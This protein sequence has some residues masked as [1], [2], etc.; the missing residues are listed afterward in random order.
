[1]TTC[2]IGFYPSIVKNQ[3]ELCHEFCTECY[4]P[5]STEWT[6]WDHTKRYALAIPDTW[7]Y[8]A[9]YPGYFYNEATYQ[10]EKCSLGW[11]ECFGDLYTN[12][13]SCSAGKVLDPSTNSCKFCQDIQNGLMYNPIL[14]IWEE[15]WGKG[16]NLGNLEWDDGNTIK[17]DGCDSNCNIEA[18]WTWTGKN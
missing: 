8:I 2:P 9:W 12:C 10:W 16:F 11:E 15:N 17:G 4:G 13:L 18:D 1:M 5:K 3:W 7:E 14:S 6:A